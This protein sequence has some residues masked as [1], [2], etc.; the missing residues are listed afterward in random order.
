MFWPLGRFVKQLFIGRID[1][2][3]I[4]AEFRAQYNRF[5]DLV[6][7]PPTVVNAHQHVNLFHPV[8]SILLDVLGKRR[9]FPYVRRIQE[10]WKMLWQVPGARKK[11]WFL[12]FLGR[13]LG[14]MQKHYGFPGNDWLMGVTDP[15]WVTDAQFFVRWLTCIPGAVVELGC[16]PGHPDLTLIGRDCKADDGLMQRRV[17]EFKLMSHPSFAQTCRRLGFALV[18]PSEICRLQARMAYAA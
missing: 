8:G 12:G 7:N 17:D 2:A 10:P 15:R 4:E 5:C 13:S 9:P 14:R 1:P 11:R 6:G 16:H 18:T 3:E